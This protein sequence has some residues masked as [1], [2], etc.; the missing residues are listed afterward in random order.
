MS[1]LSGLSERRIGIAEKEGSAAVS[2]EDVRV[3][4]SDKS[5][6]LAQ[7]LG[8]PI[9]SVLT[10]IERISVRPRD[11]LPVRPSVSFVSM[12]SGILLAAEYM[13][14][15]IGFESALE[16]FFQVDLMF[17]LENAFLQ[18]VEKVD[19]C[20]CAERSKEILLYRKEIGV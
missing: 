20:Y 5:E 4:P 15:A 12:T 9:C 8:Q 14:Y 10:E 13:K 11:V 19:G 1:R 2:E 3:A 18:P 6:Y 16:T 7:H 17:P